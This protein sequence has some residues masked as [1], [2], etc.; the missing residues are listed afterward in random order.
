[1]DLHA[2]IINL[3]CPFQEQM[4]DRERM[5]HK[6]GHRDA[7]HAAAELAIKA[8]AEQERQQA[9]IAEARKIIV[10]LCQHYGHPLPD[11]TLARM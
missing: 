8:A 9:V 3:Q 11:A 7:R 4:T 6:T 10:E 5:A 1:M 2:E